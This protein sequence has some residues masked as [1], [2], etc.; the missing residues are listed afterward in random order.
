VPVRET[1]EELIGSG[2]SSIIGASCRVVAHSHG[3]GDHRAGDSQSGRAEHHRVEPNVEG[4]KA[5]FTCPNGP[6]DAR[7]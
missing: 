5:S 4:V 7:P 3:H 2:V 6:K 1:V